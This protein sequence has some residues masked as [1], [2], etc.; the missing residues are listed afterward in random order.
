MT[1]ANQKQAGECLPNPAFGFMMTL[2]PGG[3]D[4]DAKQG[5]E[6]DCNNPRHETAMTTNKV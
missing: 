3:Q 1:H 6:H 2:D 4:R 5:R